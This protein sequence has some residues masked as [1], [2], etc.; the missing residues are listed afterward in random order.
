[1]LVKSLKLYEDLALNRI[2]AAGETINVSAE[3]G[4]LLI[5]NGFAEKTG[6][7]GGF[8]AFSESN[9]NNNE[10]SENKEMK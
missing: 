3:R 7:G 1:M 9:D 6:K 8:S 2:V 10:N 4:K 5:D